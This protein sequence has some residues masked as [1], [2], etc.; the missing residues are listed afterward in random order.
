MSTLR[1]RPPRHAGQVPGVWHCSDTT[2]MKRR[3]LNLLTALSLLLCVATVM[4][5]VRSYRVD[6]ALTRLSRPATLALPTESLTVR[7]FAGRVVVYSRETDFSNMTAAEYAVLVAWLKTVMPQ[8]QGPGWQ[9]QSPLGWP[10]P[11]T[12]FGFAMRSEQETQADAVTAKRVT[13]DAATLC[14]PHW[15][16]VVTAAALPATWPFRNRRRRRRLLQLGLCP[17]CGYDLTG[18]VSGV[19]PECGSAP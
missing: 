2:R 12:R 5:W 1:L 18:N 17:S 3:L 8:S 4:L 9:Y 15:F 10:L 14:V 16:V 13:T 11:R 19:C 6:E 7:S